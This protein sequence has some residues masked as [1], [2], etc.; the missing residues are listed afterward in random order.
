MRHSLVRPRALR[1]RANMQMTSVKSVLFAMCTV[2]LASAV[3]VGAECPRIRRVASTA[4]ACVLAVI[5]IFQ[6][7]DLHGVQM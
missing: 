5:I 4:A 3:R 2:E 7:I 1:E 6:V